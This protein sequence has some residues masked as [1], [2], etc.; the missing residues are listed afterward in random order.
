MKF[1]F[2]IL[3]VL[4]TVSTVVRA[5]TVI[6]RASSVLEACG[7]GGEVL[8]KTSIEHDGKTI[9]Y[10]STACP[11][12]KTFSNSTVARGL[13]KRQIVCSEVPGACTIECA[14]LSSAQPFAEDCQFIT[15]YLEGF[16]P[17]SFSSPAGTAQEWSYFSCTYAFVNLDTIDYSVCYLQLGYNAAI[18]TNDCFGDYPAPQATSGGGCLG[19]QTAGQKWEIMQAKA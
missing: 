15:N 19:S 18:T 14:D 7:E 3:S 8:E 17:S 12:L 9:E 1:A 5:S 13:D 2:A 16:Y 6:P 4:A 10:K 11:K